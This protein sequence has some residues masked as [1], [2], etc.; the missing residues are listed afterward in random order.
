[1]P[2]GN[3]AC[4]FLEARTVILGTKKIMDQKSQSLGGRWWGGAIPYYKFDPI[5][6][7]YNN[8]IILCYIYVQFG[9]FFYFILR[10][11][12][13]SHDTYH[14]PPLFSLCIYLSHPESVYLSVYLVEFKNANKPPNE[15]NFFYTAN[16]ISLILPKCHNH[17]MREISTRNNIQTEIA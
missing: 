2:P 15:Q 3:E 4:C 11:C 13:L 14:M 6:I 5:I 8:I 17:T 16:K 12:M 10:A 1:M 9:V 7:L